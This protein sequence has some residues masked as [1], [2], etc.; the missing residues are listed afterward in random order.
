MSKSLGNFVTIRKVAETLRPE[1]LRLL[2]HRAPLPQPGGVRR[3]RATTKGRDRYPELDEAE[4]PARLLRPDAG[5]AGRRRPATDDG[6]A[7]LRAGRQDA[8]AFLEAMDDDFN[9][10]GAIGQLCGG[11]PAGQ[12][13]ARR[14]AGGGQGRPPA[15]AGPDEAETTWN[16]A[17]GPWFLDARETED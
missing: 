14:A 17:F 2:P 11:V 3:S 13:A 6:G 1:A 10:A 12:Q 5:P 15:D 8:P 4:A 16:S 9:T 7:V